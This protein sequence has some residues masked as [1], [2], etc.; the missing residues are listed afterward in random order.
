MD[1]ISEVI[2]AIHAGR[3]SASRVH[4]YGA[5]GMR[6]PR[7][8]GIGFHVVLHGAGWLVPE[9]G[10]PVP[11]RAGDVA[12]VPYGK[13][14]GL[15]HTDEDG[16]HRLAPLELPTA[17]HGTMPADFEVI[18]GCYRLDHG[19]LHRFLRDLPPVIVAPLDPERHVQRRALIDLLTAEV[20]QELPGTGVT[21]PA[22]VDLV[23]VDALRHVA[24]RS[25]PDGGDTVADRGIAAALREIHAVPQQQWTVQRLGE[26]AG[27]SR[28]VFKRRFTA[29]VGRP[30]MTY[31]I[32]WRLNR[33]ARL[34]RETKAPLATIARQVGYSSEYA[35]AN[36]FRRKFGVAPGRFRAQVT[37]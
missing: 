33:G 8:Q 5:W 24:D 16:I 28:S 35:F 26:I 25:G 4:M 11:L 29:Q 34:L 36:A 13:S 30:P 20:S 31:L 37:A 3:P 9:S 2:G 6:L 22:L 27:M 14:H 10:R 32:D 23:L 18:L 7:I 21:R 15:S 19:Q 17:R 12:L 1:S